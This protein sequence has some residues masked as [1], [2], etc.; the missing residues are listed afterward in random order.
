MLLV[1]TDI[2]LESNAA[3]L[4]HTTR[5]QNVACIETMHNKDQKFRVVSVASNCRQSLDNNIGSDW[6]VIELLI[7]I[8]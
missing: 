4:I 6:N 1:I 3:Y 8:R 2:P 5:I 7:I